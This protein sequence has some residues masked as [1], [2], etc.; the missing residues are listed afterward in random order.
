MLRF[1]GVLRSL[2]PNAIATYQVEAEGANV[3]GASVLIPR[4]KGANMR[5]ILAVFRGE[6]PLV[7][8]PEQILDSTTTT[9]ATATTTTGATT[10][11]GPTTTVAT[12]TTV[13]TT[14]VAGPTTTAVEP[15]ENAKGVVPPRDAQC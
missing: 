7:G 1:V 2:D 14:T 8:A 5:A 3:G 10:V 9:S 4:I 15:V 6:A 13:T 11:T 12:T